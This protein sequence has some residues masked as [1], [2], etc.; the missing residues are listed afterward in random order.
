MG[1][2]LNIELLGTGGTTSNKKKALFGQNSCPVQQSG[3]SVDIN[4]LFDLAD[5]VAD[6]KEKLYQ[7]GLDVGFLDDV[8]DELMLV[9]KMEEYTSSFPTRRTA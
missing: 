4:N 9:D 3:T 1:N 7:K 8:A 2:N 6:L 5:A